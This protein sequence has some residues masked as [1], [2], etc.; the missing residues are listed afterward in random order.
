MKEREREIDFALA[1]SPRSVH[2]ICTG[3]TLNSIQFS[4]VD[5]G[6]PRT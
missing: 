6:D 1:D 2:N 4:D 3:A 5:G